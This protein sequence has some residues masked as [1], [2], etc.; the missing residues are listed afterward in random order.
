MRRMT[1]VVMCAITITG[2]SFAG[3]ERT[4]GDGVNDRGNSV[5][6]TSDGGYII[7]GRKYSV[8]DHNDD[9]YLIKTNAFGDTLWTR[10]YGGDSNDEGY[11]LAQTTDGGYIIA[12]YTYSYGEG[13]S[14]IYLIKTDISG[15]TLWTRTYGGAD[16]DFGRSVEQT[17]DGGYIIAGYTTSFSDTFADYDFFLVKTDALGDRIW[18]RTYGDLDRE[19]AYSVVQTIDGGYVVAGRALSTDDFHNDIYIVKTDSIGDT[20]WTRK[21]GGAYDDEARSIKQ[22][23]DDGYIITGRIED[24]IGGCVFLTKIDPIGDT[25][26]TRT[27]GG[28][29]G[30]SVAQTD[31]DGYI[32]AGYGIRDIYLAKTD[33]SGDTLWTR[34][35]GGPNDDCG[36]SVALTGDGGFIITGETFSFGCV[37]GCVYL[38]KTDSLGHTAIGEAPTARPE[39]IAITAFPNPFNSAV[40]ITVSGEA[41]SPLQIEIF[42]INGRMVDNVSVGA[43]LKLARAGGS[44]TLPY[45]I[46]WQPDE[47]V[48]SG[49]YLLRCKGAIGRNEIR[50]VYLK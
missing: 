13:R 47:S 15:D 16:E 42:D 48:G 28:S 40:T 10:T 8:V 45:E 2:I 4:Y 30:Y 22:T 18:T 25:L 49:I 20:L 19:Y 33:S 9:V 32:I 36:F 6:Q 27:Y 3:W 1:F 14:A 17:T 5:T 41:T 31:D 24:H 12:G 46:I 29:Y 37:C 7:V 43:G 44:E 38:I 50:L 39:E 21:F 35:H 26:W 23:A 34:S 11:S